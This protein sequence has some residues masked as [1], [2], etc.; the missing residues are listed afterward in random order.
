MLKKI[1]VICCLLMLALPF[2]GQTL[3]LAVDQQEAD[4]EGEMIQLNGIQ[5]LHSDSKIMPL[6]DQGPNYEVSL[7]RYASLRGTAYSG[8]CTA[9]KSHLNIRINNTKGSAQAY[10]EYRGPN[11]NWQQF[12]TTGKSLLGSDSSTFNVNT[13]LGNDYRL[14]IVGSYIPPS[15]ASGM[16]ACW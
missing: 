13:V 10:L 11:Q 12:S 9:T 5:P 7:G 16:V 3:A 14:R 15:G 2:S 4:Y 6:V 8:Y 1:L